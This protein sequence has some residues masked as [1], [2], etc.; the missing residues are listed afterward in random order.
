VGLSAC[1]LTV[2][3]QNN[4][5]LTELRENPTASSVRSLAT[6]LLIGARDGYETYIIT[7]GMLGREMYD[8]D[9]ASVIASELLIGPLNPSQW[10]GSNWEAPYTNLRNANVLLD[11]LPQVERLDDTQ[12]EALRGFAKTIMAYEY[13]IVINSR[14]DNGAVVEV[15]RPPTEDPGPIVERS[16]VYDRIFTLLDEAEGHL[17]NAG[18]SIP[19]EF[20][21]GFAGFSTPSSFLEFNRALKA[22][23]EIYTKDYQGALD[24][25][26]GSFV[27]TTEALTRGVYHAYGT[28]SGDVSNGLFA[29]SQGEAPNYVAPRR[30]RQ[31][32]K[33]KPNGEP[34][35]RFQEKFR[36]L[37]TENTR[38]G[39]VSDLTFTLYGSPSADIPLIRNAELVLIRAE[40]N[41]GLDNYGLAQ[42]DLNHVRTTAGGL[43]PIDDLNASNAIDQ[44][45][46][47]RSYTL[48]LEGAHRW[49]DYRRYDRLDQL[50]KEREDHKTFSAMPIPTNECL[51]RD[52]ETP[53]GA[54]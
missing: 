22:R 39:A 44:L 30:W 8:F 12:K 46:Y 21:S 52:Q 26:Q 36:T 51:A 25:L 33:T 45:L 38:V 14:S 29:Q 32:A 2:P 49:S 35:D 54:N 6:G 42:A 31:D 17:N 53:C 41:I 50:V 1:D 34:D 4:P 5:S 15:D 9:G 28:G 48:Y 11:A 13:L 27:D 24:A 40:A 23:A 20:P 16:A 10:G 37:P 7:T 43:A 3:D 19:I 47:E 18:S